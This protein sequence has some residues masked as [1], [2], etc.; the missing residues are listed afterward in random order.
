MIAAKKMIT[1]I[2]QLNLTKQT[3]IVTASEASKL[4]LFEE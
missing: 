3:E 2:D 4:N 1:E